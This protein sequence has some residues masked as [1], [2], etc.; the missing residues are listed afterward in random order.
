[1]DPNSG[2]EKNTNMPPRLKPVKP[3]EKLKNNEIGVKTDIKGFDIKKFIDKIIYL[4]IIKKLPNLILKSRGK[5]IQK[6]ISIQ[7]ILRRKVLGLYVI[8]KTYSNSYINENDNNKQ[9]KL[10]CLDIILSIEEPPNKN[11]GF[12]S[13]LP[14]E[15]LDKNYIDPKNP[16]NFQMQLNNQRGRNNFRGRYRPGFRGRGNNFFNKRGNNNYFQRRNNNNYNYNNNLMKYNYNNNYNQRR[17]NNY[18]NNNRYNNN[19]NYNYNNNNYIL[20]RRGF[21]RRGR[22]RGN[23]REG[24]K[25]ED[26]D[27]KE[28]KS[29][30]K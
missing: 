25:R 19:Y 20:R 30:N 28:F 23:N 10:P 27:Y 2:V 5:G 22:F 1:M 8:Q 18:N 17:Y 15:D 3:E 13:P 26:E 4:L 7:D 24:F 9:I 21:K 16:I 11:E 6:L 14:L 29:E 12:F